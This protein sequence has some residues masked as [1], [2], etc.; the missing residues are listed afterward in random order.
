MTKLPKKDG[1][2]KS[3]SFVNPFARKAGE[4]TEAATLEKA[5]T[6]LQDKF[7]QR[8]YYLE[9]RWGYWL[10]SIGSYF[11]SL[12]SIVLAFAFVEL[13]LYGV[14]GDHVVSSVLAGIGLCLLE[15]VKK[16]AFP[17][18][19]KMLLQQSPNVFLFIVTAVAV[20]L[21]VFSGVNGAK[22]VI[23][24][25]GQQI[26]QVTKDVEGIR[27]SY[28]KQIT[29]LRNN[30]KGYESKR[31]HSWQFHK[32][33][34]S[35]NK[36]IEALQAAKSKHVASANK[37]NEAA[38][39]KHRTNQE[40]NIY[41]LI[42]LSLFIEGVI[43]LCDGFIQLYY[44]R[45]WTELSASTGDITTYKDYT[46][47]SANGKHNAPNPAHNVA[48]FK[49]RCD[50]DNRKSDKGNTN[51]D[52]VDLTKLIRANKR[53]LNSYRGKNKKGIGT[54]KT[55]DYHI[56]RLTKEIA[57]LEARQAQFEKGATC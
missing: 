53:D 38:E 37:Y 28:D 34:E 26:E 31:K 10:A 39:V 29:D 3:I 19:V 13:L 16:K 20:G 48:G 8:A 40:T 9:Y 2:R 1:N 56:N 12:C 35:S 11:F 27:S 22:S 24:N 46:G 21:S 57:D 45:S 43:L 42:L 17:L 15:L 44:Y 6:D 5:S 14:L 30:I 23:V 4:S 47:F 18:S 36:Q 25:F 7:R 54:K 32:E 50:S 49:N 41:Y 52:S 55:N 33:I 51:Y